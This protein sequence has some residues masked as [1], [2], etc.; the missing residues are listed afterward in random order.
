MT[1]A[2]GAA[3]LMT[4][5]PT[6]TGGRPVPHERANPPKKTQMIRERERFNAD[7]NVLMAL[8]MCCAEH[9]CSPRSLP[10]RQRTVL[11]RTQEEQVDSW[12]RSTMVNIRNP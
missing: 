12:R 2:G 4:S 3:V 7:M 11:R 10:I 6:G 5:G 9:D 8:K 1:A